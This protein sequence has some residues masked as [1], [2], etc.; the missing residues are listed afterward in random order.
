MSKAF[1][2]VFIEE[3]AVR[4]ADVA[5]D[6]IEIAIVIEICRIDAVAAVFGRP[7]FD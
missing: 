4:L 2:A 3:Q 5:N 7:D 6:E 1:P